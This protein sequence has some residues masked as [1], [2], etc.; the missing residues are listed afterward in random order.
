MNIVEEIRKIEQIQADRK[1]KNRLLSYNTGGKIHKKQLAFHQCQKKNP[2]KNQ[3][4]NQKI[5]I[6]K[7]KMKLT[8][9]L[10]MKKMK[11]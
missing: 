3:M 4:K 7:K 6:Q 8:N 11:N 9:Y 1:K 10:E 5:Q 2:M